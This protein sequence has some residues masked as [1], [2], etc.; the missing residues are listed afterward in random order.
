[1]DLDADSDLKMD[2]DVDPDRVRSASRSQIAH[3]RGIYLV[4]MV[5]GWFESGSRM[6]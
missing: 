3:L 2:V 5:W 1:M 4:E 6:V